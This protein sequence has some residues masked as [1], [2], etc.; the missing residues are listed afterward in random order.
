[1][2]FAGGFPSP[3]T[4]CVAFFQRSHARHPLAARFNSDSVAR[5]GIS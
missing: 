2:T 1:M 5:D 4:V 3:K